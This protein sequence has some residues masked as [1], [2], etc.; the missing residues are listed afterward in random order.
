MN[1]SGG[2]GDYFP[3]MVPEI[4]KSIQNCNER[5]KE[6]DTNLT[7]NKIRIDEALF[8]GIMAIGS[9]VTCVLLNILAF[10][11]ITNKGLHV[12]NMT[13]LVFLFFMCIDFILKAIGTV[14]R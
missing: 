9:A 2:R 12:V 5:V 10:G 14:I 1:A 13:L 6:I 3:A 11:A 4:D 8:F 7:R